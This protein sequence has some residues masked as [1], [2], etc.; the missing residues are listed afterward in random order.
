MNSGHAEDEAKGAPVL[1]GLG[2]GTVAEESH[3][4]PFAKAAAREGTVRA[5]PWEDDVRQ[6]EQWDDLEGGEGGGLKSHVW[7]F[8]APHTL[9]A[10]NDD[11]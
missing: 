10:E 9:Y 11:D 7:R 8:S 1:G 6:E 5:H 4:E 3:S 2:A